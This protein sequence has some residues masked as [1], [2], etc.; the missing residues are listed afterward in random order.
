[1]ILLSGFGGILGAWARFLLGKWVSSKAKRPFPWGTWVINTT[2]SF[3]LGCLW[4]LYFHQSLPVWAWQFAGIGFL[5]A[6]TTFST[7]GYETVLL[8]ERKR[9]GLALTYVLSSVVVGIAAAWAG[10][11]VGM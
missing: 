8:I 1:M 9:W 6:Y 2:G 7:F 10:I 5:G 3:L 11:E 4:I